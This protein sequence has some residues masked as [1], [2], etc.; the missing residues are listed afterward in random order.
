LAKE[1]SGE[2]HLDR[3]QQLAHESCCVVP[4]P[5]PSPANEA[6]TDLRK[7]QY[8]AMTEKRFN[9]VNRCC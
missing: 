5:S 6:A 1:L 2:A 7:A 8:V 4:L 3:A 9:G